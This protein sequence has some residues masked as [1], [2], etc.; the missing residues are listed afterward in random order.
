MTRRPLVHAGV[1]RF[2]GQMLTV[3]PGEGTLPAVRDPPDPLAEGLPGCAEAG[4]VGAAAGVVGAWQ[5]MEAIKAALGSRTVARGKLL[6]IDTLSNE[7]SCLTVVRDRSCPR[8]ANIPGSRNRCRPPNTILNGL[9]RMNL[10]ATQSPPRKAVILLSGGLDSTLAARIVRDQGIE[11]TRSIS[12]RRSA[13]APTRPGNGGG[14]RSAAQEVAVGMGIPIRTVSK[15]EEY[16]EIVKHPRHGRGSAMNPCIDCRIFTLRKAKAFMEEIG[17]SFLVTG[18]SWGSDRCPSGTM[19]CAASRAQ[20]MRG[21]SSCA[22]SPLHLPPTLPEREGWV[23][24]ETPRDHRAVPQG[25][26]P[27][28]GGVRDRRLPMPRGGMHADRPDLLRQGA[29]SPR[30]S[31]FLR[32][33]RSPPPEGGT[34]FP[35]RRDQGDRGEKRRGE[36]PARG[37]LPGRDTVYVAHSHPGP[38]VTLLGGSASGRLDLLSRIFTRYGKAGSVGPYEIREISPTGSDS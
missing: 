35:C 23:D 15:G 24:R 16:L 4:I 9:R 21:G 29:G 10:P 7:V 34:A 28:R 2:G 19:R 6:T 26:D 17:A 27:P 37:T 3:V 33:A 18:K 22:R 5:A 38:S 14:C 25:T 12:P 30:P 32:D 1:L 36:P 20:R 13:P 8:A 11:L 31:P